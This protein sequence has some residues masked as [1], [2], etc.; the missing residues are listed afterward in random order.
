MPPVILARTVKPLQG[1]ALLALSALLF[2]L[3]GVGIREVS[4]SVNNES[5]VFFRNLVGVVFFLPLI[6][7]KGFAP[8]RTQRLPGHLWRTGYGLAAMY[9]FFYAI[10]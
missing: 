3:M 1:A 6:L 7:L 2:S 4:L 9:C 8:L 5:V 10:A